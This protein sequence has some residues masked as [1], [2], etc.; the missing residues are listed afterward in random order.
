M[1]EDQ[2]IIL[3]EIDYV[4]LRHARGHAHPCQAATSHIQM[5]SCHLHFCDIH[6]LFSAC[7]GL[8]PPPPVTKL[9]SSNPS[10]WYILSRLGIFFVAIFCIFFL[11]G[12][13]RRRLTS[14][15]V[16]ERGPLQRHHSIEMTPQRLIDTEPLARHEYDWDAFNRWIETSN[17]LILYL[18][19]NLVIP[20][21]K[22][23]HRLATAHRTMPPVIPREN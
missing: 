17:L 14:R 13:A 18:S 15:I 7:D 21:P 3:L 4:P 11:S 22:S 20:L 23:P 16:N 8:N 9:T 5:D 2:S 6:A 19:G 10:G 1:T 12:I